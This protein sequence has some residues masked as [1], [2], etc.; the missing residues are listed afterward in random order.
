MHYEI[1][2]FY[3]GYLRFIISIRPDDIENDNF[4][5]VSFIFIQVFLQNEC[6]SNSKSHKWI[7]FKNKLHNYRSCII[8][9][10]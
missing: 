7:N 4:F 2:L 8:I 3:V 9:L 10:R 5:C 1:K 6:S